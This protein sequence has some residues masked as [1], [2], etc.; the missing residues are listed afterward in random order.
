[1]FATLFVIL[2]G[3]SLAALL[4]VR[5]YRYPMRTALTIA[6]SLAQIGEF[7]F[8]LAGMGVALQ[9]LPP[10]GRDLI[11]AGALLSILANPLFF[12]AIDRFMPAPLPQ[13]QP[14][15]AD[16]P[17]E[18]PKPGEVVEEPQEIPQTKLKDH[19]VLIGYG[20]VGS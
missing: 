9:V 6:A 13:A 1:V 12:Y 4:I 2:I 14:K 20:R 11:L 16:A 17:A 19:A 3:K 7:S 18:P 5:L 15:A 10:E 8:I